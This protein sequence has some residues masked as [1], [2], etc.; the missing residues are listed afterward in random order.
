MFEAE[1]IRDWRQYDVVDPDGDKVG[2]M[3]SVYVDTATDVPAFAAVKIG[4]V[5]RR[6]LTF[7][8]LA[9]ATVAP[10]HVRVAYPK[11]LVRRAPTIQT[12]GEL[13]AEEEPGLFEHYGLEYGSDSPG[14]RRLARR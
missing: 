3:E 9:G 6:R 4:L 13:L 10:R 14:V 1:N 5:G 11:K 8:P 12:D 2:E 7:V